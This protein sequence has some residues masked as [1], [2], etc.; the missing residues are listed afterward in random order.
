MS[1]S[2]IFRSMPVLLD[3]KVFRMDKG[4]PFSYP[5]HYHEENSEFLLIVEGEGSFRVDG[6]P[7]QARSGHLLCY[8]RTVWHEEISTSER[9][10]AMYIGFKGLQ[11]RDLPPD[12]FLERDRPQLIALEEYFIPVKQLMY[13]L[14][15]E[16]ESTAPESDAIA[17]QLLGVL[18]CR[19][20]QLVHY[21]KNVEYRKRPSQ[22]AVLMAKRYIEE[23]YQTDINL[24]TL[25]KL[26][27]LNHYHFSH[28]FKKETGQSPIQHLISYRVEVSK[29]YLI[30][31]RKSMG[32]IAELV[33]YK[34]E[35]YFQ[36]IFKKV[37]GI[38]PGRYRSEFWKHAR[39]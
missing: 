28:L 1:V 17:D 30:T 36:N 38:S 29:Q 34:S 19:L 24:K 8:N 15:M 10:H 4:Q 35:T 5:L 3:G 22:D 16:H 27:H 20:S 18:I 14:I 12:F 9:F 26:T 39:S 13:D 25:A 11:I 32:E 2:T 23:K 6:K 31:T 21:K 7:Y 37:A 33:G